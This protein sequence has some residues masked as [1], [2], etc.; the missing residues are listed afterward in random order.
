MP[1]MRSNKE[2]IEE[3]GHEYDKEKYRVMLLESGPV[4]GF[5]GFGWSRYDSRDSSR[6]KNRKWWH[7]LR[8]QRQKDIDTERGLA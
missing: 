8:E 4:L 7:H 3:K 6:S 5:F 2:L 1:A